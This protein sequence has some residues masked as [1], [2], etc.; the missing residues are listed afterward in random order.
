MDRSETFTALNGLRFVAA[1]AVVFFHFATKIEGYGHAPVVVRSLISE[2]PAAVAFFFILSGFVLAHRYLENGAQIEEPAN[3]YWSRFTRLYPAYILAFLLFLPLAVVKYLHGPGN[4]QTF[5]LAASLS[6][7]MLQAWTPLA[8]A[9]NGPSWSLSVEAFMYV[10]FPLLAYRLL[11]LDSRTM[12]LILTGLWLL[13]TSLA[14]AYTAGFIP[15]T[16]WIAYI[17]NN[18]LLWTP[19]FLIGICAIRVLPAWRNVTRRSASV[20]STVAGLVLVLT[21]CTWPQRWSEIFITGGAAPLLAAVVVSFSRLSGWLTRVIGGSIL[22]RLG[23]ASYVVYI[24]Q[25]PA[26]HYW[27]AATNHLRHVPMET[28]AVAGWQFWLFVPFLVALSLLVQHYVEAPARAWLGRWRD[29]IASPANNRRFAVASG[30]RWS[31]P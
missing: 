14:I 2:G 23:Q 13:P 20:T 18:P 1:L 26:W 15:A 17:Q 9:W 8:Q 3:F 4:H 11:R 21:A 30:H 24:L 31:N 19:L 22:D 6:G 7:L 29:R 5:F 12:V 25:S 27:Q 16:I 28:V 10:V